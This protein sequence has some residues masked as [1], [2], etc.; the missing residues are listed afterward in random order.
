MDLNCSNYTD[1]FLS[2]LEESIGDKFT[3]EIDGTQLITC[4]K[5]TYTFLYN[6][7]EEE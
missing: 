6:K 7:T 5:N 1:V 2:I 4:A 3:I